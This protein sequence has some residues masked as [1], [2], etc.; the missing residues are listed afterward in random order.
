MQKQYTK[1]I[2]DYLV[3]VVA[4]EL[5]CPQ[6]LVEDVI[7]WVYK[8]TK[9][10]AHFVNSME[11]S[12]LGTL[13]VTRTKLE[14]RIDRMNKIVASVEKKAKESPQSEALEKRRLQALEALEFLKNKYVEVSTNS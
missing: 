3:T 13:L 9:E 8:D 1:E 2:K 14:R 6:K 7:M 5:E 4:K 11:L 10:N 12:G